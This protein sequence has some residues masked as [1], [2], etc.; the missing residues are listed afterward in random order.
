MPFERSRSVGRKFDI[1]CCIGHDFPSL[2][3]T[4]NRLL[5]EFTKSKRQ[6]QQ[7]HH[8]D[9]STMKLLNLSSFSMNRK[10]KLVANNKGIITI[11]DDSVAPTQSTVS[12][13]PES[14]KSQDSCTTDSDISSSSRR[15]AFNEMNNIYYES[16]QEE[17]DYSQRWLKAEEMKE[18]K[19]Q[20]SFLAREIYKSDKNLM[21]GHFTYS[22][23]L[24]DAYQACMP[25]FDRKK[26]PLTSM[27]RQHLALYVQGHTVR[28]GLERLCIR[29]LAQDKRN[30]RKAVVQAVLAV[31]A[32]DNTVQGIRDASMSVSQPSRLFA[33]ELARAQAEC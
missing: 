7:T 9:N 21:N 10:R 24:L 20:A 28:L 8:T 5:D 30:R 19:T 22:R 12:T 2:A 29:D 31:Q 33:Y 16:T 4:E 6:S 1:P 11:D 27:E 17:E 32:A 14:C 13:L 18:C 15:V 25:S 3:F 26:A 23:V